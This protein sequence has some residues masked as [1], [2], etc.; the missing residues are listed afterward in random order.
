MMPRPRFDARV[1]ILS[2]VLVWALAS[3]FTL[4]FMLSLCVA[5]I[6]FAV[7]L[8]PFYLIGTAAEWWRNRKEPVR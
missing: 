2:T 5:A 3:V 7:A 1:N 8:G 4:L 6:A